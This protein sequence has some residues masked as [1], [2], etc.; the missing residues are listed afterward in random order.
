MTWLKLSGILGF[1]AVAAGAFGAHGLRNRV[2][3]NLLDAYQTGAHYHLVHAVAL[4]ALALYAR[5]AQ[6]S[7]QLPALCWTAGIVLFSGSLYAMALSG[8]TK[9][10]IITPFGGL[11]FLAGWI[12]LLW[13]R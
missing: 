11:A 6:V 4:L 10:G 1:L 12:G 5:S 13:L 8:V 7:I 3:A 2:A 9:L